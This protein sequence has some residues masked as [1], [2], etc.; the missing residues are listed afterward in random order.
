MSDKWLDLFLPLVPFSI[1]G[2]VFG[3]SIRKDVLTKRQRVAAGLFSLCMGPVGALVVTRDLGW[4]EY[5]GWGVAAIVPTLAYDAVGMLTAALRYVKDNPG[6]L[7]D[8]WPWG[9]K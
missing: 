8:L 6:A 4:S 2:A 7:K 3:D 5:A 9:K 1:A